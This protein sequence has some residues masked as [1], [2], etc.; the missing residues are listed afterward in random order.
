MKKL[1]LFID[2]LFT[3]AE[4][5]PVAK[6]SVEELCNKVGV[7]RQT[8]YYHFNDMSD[9]INTILVDV[10]EHR[11]DKDGDF[12]ADARY[13]ADIFA[14][15]TG[16]IKNLLSSPYAIDVTNFLHDYLSTRSLARLS[17]SPKY[18]KM[19]SEQLE[20]VS[21]IVASIL[22]SEFS[23]WI[24]TGL[25]EDKEHLITRF[26]VMLRNVEK[27]MVENALRGS[28]NKNR[29]SENDEATDKH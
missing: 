24:K 3:L 4:E 21:R 22:V 8:F 19:P 9:L 25:Q 26:T 15:N 5:K 1:H 10:S 2:A 18:K 16:A 17:S 23:Y 14:A 11:E 27:M 12:T 29:P 28:L 7:K 6:I 13:V 20:S